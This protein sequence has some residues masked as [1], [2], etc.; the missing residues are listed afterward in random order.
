VPDSLL[1]RRGRESDT[2]KGLPANQPAIRPWLCG[3]ASGMD[4]A[5]R[6]SSPEAFGGNPPSK[7]R[8]GEPTLDELTIPTRRRPPLLAMKPM[9]MKG[10][11][12]S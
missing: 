5:P 11:C 8:G 10:D 2:G 6:M 12:T 7:N 3:L 9:S 1:R 4:G